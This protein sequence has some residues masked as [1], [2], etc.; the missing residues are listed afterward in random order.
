VRRVALVD[1]KGGL[2]RAGAAF[3]LLETLAATLL[4]GMVAVA[5]LPLLA[6]R[7]RQ[8][9]LV[10]DHGEARAWLHREVP[11]LDPGPYIGGPVEVPGCPSWW[12]EAVPLERVP[13]G[14]ALAATP[15]AVAPRHAWVRWQIT[16]GRGAGAACIA[17]DLQLRLLQ[18]PGPSPAPTG[19][20]DPASPL[21]PRTPSLLPP[22]FG[23]G[24]TP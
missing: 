10:R 9:S 6:Q 19:S 14:T 18:D 2:A 22:A 1:R 12:L 3:T 8:E 15:I 11:H 16:D 20:P 21:P 13:D 24:P 17:W 4:L 23:A 5:V 7:W